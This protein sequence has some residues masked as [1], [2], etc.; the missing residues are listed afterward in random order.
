MPARPQGGDTVKALSP[1][2]AARKESK[3]KMQM[4]K[5]VTPRGQ[6]GRTVDILTG[7]GQAY[8]EAVREDPAFEVAKTAREILQAR[9]PQFGCDPS[10]PLVKFDL[11]CPD[12]TCFECEYWCKN[13][14]CYGCKFDENRS[15]PPRIQLQYLSP[16][17]RMFC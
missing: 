6:G 3:K 1:R 16:C 5:R 4:V 14:S 2:K 13:H 11:E 9:P 7:R 12:W 10:D 15:V 8:I 17:N